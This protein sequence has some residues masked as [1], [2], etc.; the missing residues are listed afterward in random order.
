[1][2]ENET[3]DDLH[4]A[5]LLVF[6]EKLGFKTGY[7]QG[8][9]HMVIPEPLPSMQKNKAFVCMVEENE[10]NKNSNE[11]SKTQL[12]KMAGEMEEFWK[13]SVDQGKQLKVITSQLVGGRES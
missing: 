5:S 3:S 6:K 11:N 12:E 8:M 13:A 2:N 10:R 1:M 4:E 7:A 9:G